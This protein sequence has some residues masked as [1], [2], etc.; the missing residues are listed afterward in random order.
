MNYCLVSSG[1]QLLN[2]YEYSKVNHIKTKFFALYDTHTEKLQISNTSNYL[3]IQSLVLI[4]RKKIKTYFSLLLIFFNKRVNSFII[5]HLEDNHMLFA[6]KI[7]KSQKFILVD[8]G[9]S[10]LKNYNRYF[11]QKKRKIKYPKELFFFSIF[12]L[13]NNK[14]CSKN[15]LKHILK[16]K[17]SISNEVF[18]IGQPMEK[19]FGVSNYYLT[20]EKIIDLNPNMI[21]IPHRR[22]SYQKLKYI[23]ESLGIRVFNIDEIIELFLIKSTSIP[24][25]VISFYSTSL[26]TLKIL[27][28]EQID[29][30]YVNKN[31][32]LSSE[33]I[34]TF[35]KLNIKNEL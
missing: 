7:V 28:K 15:E 9:M 1:F 6:S 2:V 22:D 21:Y 19:L 11:D 12:N 27:F 3:K 34:E 13:G 14:Y 32:F 8:D 20:L 33:L 10:T 35:E 18:F 24:K 5:G 31:R 17:K 23:K 16:T 26:I 25:K 29:F 30:N 4:Q